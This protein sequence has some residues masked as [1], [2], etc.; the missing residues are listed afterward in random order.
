M[1]SI[2]CKIT[3]SPDLS[4]YFR[5]Y[6]S[7]LRFS[8]N[9]IFKDKKDTLE[10]YH[11]TKTLNNTK[12]LDASFR[13][14]AV[15]E[16]KQI[17]SS[18]EERG[19]KKII[20]GGKKG[21]WDLKFKKAQKSEFERNSYFYCIGR[22][23]F[24]GNRKFNFDLLNEKV[25]FKPE[26]DVKICI[27]FKVPSN[28][29]KLLN[30]AQELADKKRCS[31]SVRVNK[32]YIIFNVDEK[33]IQ[34]Q[35]KRVVLSRV[36]AI[37]SNPEF[38]G[39]T[40]SDF[41]GDKQVVVHKQV[42]NLTGL[43]NESKNKRGHEIFAISKSIAKLALHFKCGVVGL[44][45]LKIKSKDHKKGKKFNKKVN[46]LWNRTKFFN[47]LKKWLNIFNVKFIEVLPQYSSLI[48][49]FNFP[50]ETDS[51]AASLEIARRANLFDRIYLRK[52]E[53]KRDI[54]FP[55]WTN[56]ILETTRWK[57]MFHGKSF[58]SWLQLFAHIKESKLS[59]RFLFRDWKQSAVFFSFKSYTSKVICYQKI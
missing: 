17:I 2:K 11:L 39:L 34:H 58:T 43:S 13:E 8:Y 3:N 25:V 18:Q 38:I 35:K 45:K 33:I 51:V 22:A 30:K 9:R 31:I 46:N 53:E 19:R 54:L 50:E 26:R 28:Y 20:F 21:F 48:G 5:Q 57:E 24:K 4:E 44:E 1:I 40:V 23:G 32:E 42:F 52:V 59:Y 37:D 36:L 15:Q 6:G 41:C 29:K 16:A 47:N 10:T 56:D 7:V 55:V 27:E 14:F 12:L 49:Q